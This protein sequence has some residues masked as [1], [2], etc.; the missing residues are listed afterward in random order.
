[1]AE[2]VEELELPLTLEEIL[3]VI[4]RRTA[5]LLRVERASV[6]LLDSSGT[7]LFVCGRV[8]QPVHATA[9]TEFKLGEGLVGW[10]AQHGHPLRTGNAEADP[11]F[12]ARPDQTQAIGSFLGMPL[13]YARRCVGVLSAVSPERDAFSEDDERWVHLLA[14]LCAPRLEVAR[15][16]HQ[17]LLEGTAGS[18]LSDLL[19]RV[20]PSQSLSVSALLVDIDGFKTLNAAYGQA[21]GDEVLRVVARCLASSLRL[22]DAVVRHGGDR[23]LLVLAG[24]DLDPASRIAERLRRAVEVSSVPTPQGEVAVTASIAV[25]HRQLDEPWDRF[26]ERLQA[27]LGETKATGT[28][29]VRRASS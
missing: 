2:V 15:L 27:T 16:A 4:S 18:R 14:G 23:F 8:G 22:G 1:M 12:V 5:K 28:N 26:F 24:L 20:L 7:R 3:G 6:R 19:D 10:V 25:A 9:I 13:L 29:R 11:R 17:A 21:A